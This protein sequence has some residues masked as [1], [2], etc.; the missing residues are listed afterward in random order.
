MPNININNKSIGMYWMPWRSFW[1][2][3]IPNEMDFN[4][5]SKKTHLSF[6]R[7]AM[8]V[9]QICCSLIWSSV[10]LYPKSGKLCIPQPPSMAARRNATRWRK[11]GE[12]NGGF[13]K[14]QQSLRISYFFCIETSPKKGWCFINLNPLN[15]IFNTKNMCCPF[16]LDH[17]KPCHVQWWSMLKSHCSEKSNLNCPLI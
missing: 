9:A 8:P 17:S 12:G 1:N 2:P 10:G 5:H 14:K 3:F 16:W 6:K 15:L 13:I 11:H 7:A 4:H